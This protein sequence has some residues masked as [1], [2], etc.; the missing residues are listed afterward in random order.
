[1]VN[2]AILGAGKIAKRMA[3]SLKNV[4]GAK[5]Y[6]I[7]ARDEE[8]AEVF[9]EEFN[10]EKIYKSEEELLNDEN[11][12]VVY[13][14]SITSKHFEY[15]KMAIK[16]HKAVLVEKPAFMNY[17]EAKEIV[18]LAKQNNVLFMEALK[19][20]FVPAYIHLKEIIDNNIYGKVLS[21]NTQLC[22]F[23]TME[24]LKKTHVYKGFNGGCLHDVGPYCLSYFDDFIDDLKIERT[25]IRYVDSVDVHTKV[26]FNCGSLETAFDE[27]REKTCLIKLEKGEIFI[28]DL[29]RPTSLIINGNEESY[30]YINDDFYGQLDHFNKLYKNGLKESKVVPFKTTLHLASIYDEVLKNTAE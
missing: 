2:W 10:V 16:H 12:D 28:P 17:K 25:D 27:K 24:D 4:E 15:A 6:G 22:S 14:S 8:K 11:V 19:T 20:R 3:S 7:Y 9:S 30:P 23:Y 18:D 5:L 26:N 21:I 1:M 13:I 29:H